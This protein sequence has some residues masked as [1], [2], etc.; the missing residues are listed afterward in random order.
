MAEESGPDITNPPEPVHPSPPAV[1]RVRLN[2]TELASLDHED[3]IKQWNML[4]AYA[5]QL[6]ARIASQ[7]G[8]TPIVFGTVS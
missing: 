5:D 3:L 1:H 4:D 2:S 6:E 7:Q 8:R